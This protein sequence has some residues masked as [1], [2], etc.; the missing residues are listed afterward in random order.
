[1]TDLTQAQIRKFEDLLNAMSPENVACD[2]EASS[3]QQAATWRRLKSDRFRR[4]GMERKAGHT[5]DDLFNSVMMDMWPGHPAVVDFGIESQKHY[6]ALYD[7]IRKGEIKL[8]DLRRVVGDGQEITNLVNRYPSNRHRNQVVFKTAYDR[9]KHGAMAERI[10]SGYLK[11]AGNE[12]VVLRA[13]GD[14]LSAITHLPVEYAF[15]GDERAGREAEKK[16][17]QAIALLEDVVQSLPLPVSYN[18][19]WGIGSK[20]VNREMDS[21]EELI[22]Y[23]MGRGIKQ[24]G[25]VSRPGLRRE[26][27]GQPTFDKLLGP[28]YDGPKRVR[29]ETQEAYDQLSA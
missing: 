5:A 29:Y 25:V 28:M 9:M 23:L 21:T 17:K 19:V 10:A 27:Q 12:S 8:S 13:L 16:V 2:G 11:T 4:I 24:T 18:V 15:S 3:S 20:L 1:M 6:E 14:A 22:R 7:P 26:L